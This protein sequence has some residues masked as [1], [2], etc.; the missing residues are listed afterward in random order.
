VAVAGEKDVVANFIVVQMLKGPVSV[1]NVALE[2]LET[3]K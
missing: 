2:K 1:R 3:E